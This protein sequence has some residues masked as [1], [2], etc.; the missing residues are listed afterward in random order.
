MAIL[1]SLHRLWSAA[2]VTGGKP[3]VNFLPEIV[4]QAWSATMVGRPLTNHPPLSQRRPADA[5]VQGCFP[6]P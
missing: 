5:N 3:G 1:P 2:R 4:D 6:S